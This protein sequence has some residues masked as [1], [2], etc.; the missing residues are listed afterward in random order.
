MNTDSVGR[1][2]DRAQ[3]GWLV[4]A[5][6]CLGPQQEDSKAEGDLTTRV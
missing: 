6:Q 4:Y 2:L 3:R 5:L 1:N